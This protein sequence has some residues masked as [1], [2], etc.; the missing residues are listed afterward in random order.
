MYRFFVD[1]LSK[2]YI[3]WFE[4]QMQKINNWTLAFASLGILLAT[5]YEAVVTH[6]SELLISSITIFALISWFMLIGACVMG[7]S[8]ILV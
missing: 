5:T 7:V 3:A 2:K 4:I 8:R 6:D 1:F